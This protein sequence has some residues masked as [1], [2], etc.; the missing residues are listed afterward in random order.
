MDSRTAEYY[1]GDVKDTTELYNSAKTGGA[2]KYFASS[3]PSGSSVLD[4]GCGSGR[5]NKQYPAMNRNKITMFT[6]TQV[7]FISTS[8]NER[9]K[10]SMEYLS[11]MFEAVEITAIQRSAGRW[12]G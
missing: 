10:N 3:F 4:I 9:I 12:D 11:A 8:L 6:G 7:P 2:G 5:D 1:S